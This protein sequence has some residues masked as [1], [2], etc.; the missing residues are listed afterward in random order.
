MGK[1]ILLVEDDFD[2]RYVLSLVLRT[3]GYD[4]LTAADGE[5][6]FSVAVE[7]TPDLMI[8]DISLPRL[9]GIEL[10]QRMKLRAETATIPVLAIT[11]YG[12]TTI[13]HALAAGACRC[14]QKPLDFG[15]FLVTV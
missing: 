6:A 2:T 13:N 9:N 10:M 4:V 8:C 12:P 3:E 15:E 7:K 11:A 14:A 1:K 5:C